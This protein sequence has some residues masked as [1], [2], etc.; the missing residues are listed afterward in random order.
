MST[1]NNMSIEHLGTHGDEGDLQRFKVAVG[2]LMDQ[3]ISEDRAIDLVWNNGDF[4]AAMTRLET[5]GTL[6]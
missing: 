6:G 2:I 1:L 4:E 3:G 5:E